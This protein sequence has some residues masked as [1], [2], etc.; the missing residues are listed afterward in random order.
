MF[1]EIPL[2][3]VFGLGCQF[4]EMNP[5]SDLRLNTPYPPPK[6]NHFVI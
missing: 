6:R 4:M 2:K 5:K 1:V 3:A